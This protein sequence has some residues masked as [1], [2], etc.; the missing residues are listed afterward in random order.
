MGAVNS[1]PFW[2]AHRMSSRRCDQPS[3][4]H[5]RSQA[6]LWGV[7]GPRFPARDLSRRSGPLT[8]SDVPRQSGKRGKAVA[9]GSRRRSPL[10]SGPRDLAISGA[11][12]AVCQTFQ[13]VLKPNSRFTLNGVQHSSPN[14]A[15]T[16]GILR[17]CRFLLGADT[18]FVTTQRSFPE[19]Q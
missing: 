11:E 15:Q 7:I 5:Y 13:P 19:R 2:T 3:R 6:D 8:A 14:C 10:F 4:R 1:L 9:E 17:F 18:S 16:S 12:P